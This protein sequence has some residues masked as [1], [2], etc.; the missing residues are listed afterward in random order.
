MG[1]DEKIPHRVSADGMSGD[2]CGGLFKVRRVKQL[3]AT[4]SN[5]V[6][7]TSIPRRVITIPMVVL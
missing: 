6:L 7:G 5:I 4:S 1:V 2:V 3:P